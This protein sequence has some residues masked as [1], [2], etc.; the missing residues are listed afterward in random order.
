VF[1]NAGLVN[2]PLEK[3]ASAINMTV[4]INRREERQ[5]LFGAVRVISVS[6]IGSSLAVIG[7]VLSTVTT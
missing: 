1:A 6:C 4:A 3:V 2:D 7:T 5:S